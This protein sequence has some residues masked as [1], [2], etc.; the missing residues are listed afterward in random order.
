MKRSIVISCA[1]ILTL[2]SGGCETDEPYTKGIGRYP[3]D[4]AENFSPALVADNDTYRNM[5]QN[6]VT[7]HSSSYDYNLTGQLVTDGIVTDRM[8]CFINVS[9]QDGDLE[10]REKEW[11]F[12]GKP[13]SKYR[14]KGTDIFLQLQLNNHIPDVDCM[15]LTGTMTYNPK[16]PKS[17]QVAFFGSENGVEWIPIKT[18]KSNNLPGTEK[19]NPYAAWANMPAPPKPQGPQPSYT[20]TYDPPKP[21]RELRLIY[22][23]DQPVHYA[24]YKVQFN[25]PCA[26][27]W[28]FSDW[29][30]YCNNQKLNMLPSGYFQSAWMSAGTGTEWICVDLG[31]NAVIDKVTLHWLNKAVKGSVQVSGDATAWTN[32]AELPG[33]EGFVDE[34]TINPRA[35]GRY[36]R[37][38]MEESAGGNRYVLSELEVFGKGGLVPVVSEDPTPAGNK[39]P[40][41]GGNWKIQRASEVREP[42]EVIS[43]ADYSGAVQW[44][45]ATVP[46]TVLSSYI[47]IG[48][49]PDP[50]YAANQLQ[51]SESFF[52]SDFWYRR[53][54]FVPKD[55]GKE[56]IF[57]NLD[58]INWK[59][60]LFVN[61]TNA[62]R[63]EGAF[64]RGK[65]NVT[66]LL[67]PGQS[68]VLAVK[69]I[70]NDNVGAV[71]EQNAISPDQ[72]GGILGADNPTFH[73]SV[74]WDWIPTIRG[75]NT[76]IW[77][78]VYLTTSGVVTIEDPFVRTGLALP[79][80]TKA[81]IR[82]EVLLR[83]H[84]DRVVSGVLEGTFGDLPFNQE[85]VLEPNA[86]QTVQAT[87]TMENPKLWW[88][89]GYGA[90]YLYDVHIQ[91][92]ADGAVS[93]E[94]A[95]QSGV[96]Q[97]SF[98]ENNGILSLYINGR[99]FIGRGGNWGFSE[100][101]LNY[102][103]REYDIAVA[104]H[105]DMNFTMIRN[106]VGQIGDDEFYEAC[107]RHGIMV[108]QDFWLANPWDGPDPYDND[109]F[110]KNA[111]DLVKR[112]RNHPSI[113]IYVGRNEGNPPAE[114]DNALRKMIPQQ[115]PGIHYISH[116]A[117]GVV[118]GGGPYRAL[119][120][121]DYFLLY[122]KDRLHS[123][124]GMPNVMTWESLSQTLSPD[125]LWPQNDQWGMHDYTLEGAQGAASFNK[126]VEEGFGP[127]D[128]ARQ[129]TEYA[130]WFNYN[131]YRGIFEGRSEFRR[132]M[133]LWMSHPAW[134]SMVWQTYDY[135]FDPTAAYFGCKKANEPLH[136][137]W[138]PVYHDI[139]VVN[140][141]AGT[142]EKLTAKAM[143]VN[144][145][146]TVQWE[147]DTLLNSYEDSTVKC[148]RLEFPESLSSVHFIKLIL[149]ENGRTVSDNFYWR[150]VE[151]GNYK[152]LK[153]M[154][155]V[156]LNK[157]TTLNKTGK[158]WKITT[159][160]KNDMSAP[161]LMI[162]LQVKGK[163][164]G[165]RIL[166]VFFSDNYFSLLPGD[167]KTVTM[168]FCHRD[169]RGEKPIVTVSG[170]NLALP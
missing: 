67:L 15:E 128:N 1:G 55:F 145:D 157:K 133:L 150:G 28:T 114:L 127:A 166:P 71:K 168:T 48:A 59:A 169:T 136:I 95:F 49:L 68:N 131:G 155:K 12:D 64:I 104:Y 22:R 7:F 98:D 93:D 108:W 124:R 6:R 170:F 85:V 25:V 135:Y 149:T 161:C 163:N 130:Q 9:D 30:F 142:H 118:S 60:D 36:V 79:D 16:A 14:M 125:A 110:M 38:L 51:V 39:L 154:P 66:Q 88:P 126:M 41:N 140:L 134:P 105:A 132:G 61:G 141:H 101:N 159:V 27:D 122:G 63:M 73:A 151:E 92:T 70:K 35:K 34:I 84:K 65:F 29:N 86:A 102:R 162:R 37:I 165:E 90:P 33:G 138:N 4:P 106:W 120:V 45:V 8:P 46:A 11:F 19:P 83:N 107:D 13:D 56:E 111:E 74:G 77:N 18:D 21:E 152:A 144:M 112:I 103:G 2:L 96:R 160:L 3:G 158:N 164:T 119:P 62:G 99:R 89:K 76:G 123:E 94:T 17:S 146:G 72:N 43:S 10:K 129:F 153:D 57:L 97:M 42:G 58:G 137:Q 54:F 69:I 5:A 109:L 78:D 143:L 100:S 31:A 91:F 121:R 44:P 47:N 50:N 23:F 80:T 20:F 87:L 24:F 147:K 32:V 115:H 26:E 82:I 148:F 52:T 167:E 156:T 75:R 81:D 139:E 113:A 117:A 40:L 53:E 116:S